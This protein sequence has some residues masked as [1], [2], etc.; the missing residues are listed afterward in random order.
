MTNARCLIFPRLATPVAVR[1]V[2]R[3]PLSRD[4]SFDV[5]VCQRGLRREKKKKE[6]DRRKCGI[7]DDIKRK[8]VAVFEK[9]SCF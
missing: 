8:R 7:G 1:R 6:T 2:H 9:E 4:H 3:A 5:G